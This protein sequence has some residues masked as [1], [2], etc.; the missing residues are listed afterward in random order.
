MIDWL[1]LKPLFQCTENTMIRVT[2]DHATSCDP[3]HG[4]YYVGVATPC[5]ELFP[6]IRG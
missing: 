1:A 5:I 4:G 6:P 2:R 3:A